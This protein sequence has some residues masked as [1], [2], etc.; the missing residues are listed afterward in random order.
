MWRVPWVLYVVLS[1]YEEGK[2][3]N[4]MYETN[5]VDIAQDIA[6]T[7]NGQLYTLSVGSTIAT[8][9][10]LLNVNAKHV[11][12]QLDGVIIQRSDYAA[13]ILLADCKLEIVTIVG[14]G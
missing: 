1:A 7:A 13:T 12:V 6:I 9:L 4:T 10:S 8:L 11:V 2:V 14:G 5:E 3:K